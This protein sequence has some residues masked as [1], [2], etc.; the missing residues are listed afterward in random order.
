MPLV[1]TSPWFII[2][3]QPPTI[4]LNWPGY[5]SKELSPDLV[6]RWSRQ[7]NAIPSPAP[8]NG[9]S[10]GPPIIKADCR[11]SKAAPARKPA[12]SLNHCK[13]NLFHLLK[14]SRFTRKILFIFIPSDKR[15]PAIP[16]NFPPFSP[17]PGLLNPLIMGKGLLLGF[18]G[19][20]AAAV[21][22]LFASFKAF[23]PTRHFNA[24]IWY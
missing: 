11:T 2:H 12:Y 24:C 20:F 13:P 18:K 16:N 6:H 9:S 19:I 23:L 8:N 1:S 3:N 4:S 10:T 7:E 14:M 21:P 22:A 5:A 17:F 15:E